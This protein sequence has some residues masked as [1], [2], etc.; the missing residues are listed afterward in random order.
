MITLQDIKGRR[1][2]DFNQILKV[3]KR[4]TPDRY[5]LFEFFL[6]N[7]IFEEV[8]GKKITTN[9]QEEIQKYIIETYALLGYDYTTLHAGTFHFDNAGTTQTGASVSMNEGGVIFDRESF[10]AYRWN[11]PREF[12]NGQ[13]DRLAPYL[14]QGMKF[15][16]H[17]WGGVL[18][19]VI[20]LTGYEN[21]CI[22]IYEDPELV[23][24]IF[25]QVGERLKTY[26]S[27]IIGNPSVGAII[28][29]DDWGFNTQTMLSP[30]DMRKYVFPHHKR[31]VDLAHGAGKPIILHSCGQLDAVYDDIIDKMGFDGKHSYE[32]NILSVE[33]AYDK[34]HERI[35][36]IGGLDLDFV[37]RSSQEEIIKRS[38]DMLKKTGGTGYALGTGNS[39]PDYVPSGNYY[40]MISA[41]ILG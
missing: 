29:N 11:D 21:L 27:L 8:T 7:N 14:P 16:V 10:N 15:I 32:D 17:S 5:T 18:E 2:P 12:Y 41:A 39:I 40:A 33:K 38:G 1:T 9:D 3:L 24:D 37:C 22:M 19:N 6:N 4:E 31:L 23:G 28:A 36:V 35:A 13:L 26:Y 25:G 20:K 30:D 34:L